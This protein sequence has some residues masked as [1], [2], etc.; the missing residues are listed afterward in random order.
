[1]SKIPDLKNDLTAF[2][3]STKYKKDLWFG[4]SPEELL[5]KVFT[6]NAISFLKRNFN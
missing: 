2:L 6:L 3:H 5:N 4:Y 1:M